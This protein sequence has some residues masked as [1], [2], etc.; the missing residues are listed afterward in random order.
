MVSAITLA[1]MTTFG[2]QPMVAR[3]RNN[4]D[5][6]ALL[7]TTLPRPESAQP[8]TRPRRKPVMLSLRDWASS[9]VAAYRVG[10]VLGYL[11]MMYFG[12]SAFIA[13]IPTFE[14]TTPRGWTPIWSAVVVI[15]GLIGGIGAVKAGTE[16][17][18]RE[19]RVFNRIELTGAIMLFL[20]LGTYATVLLILGYGY[21]DAGRASAGAGFVALGIHP[22]IRMLWLIFRPRFLAALSQ[23]PNTG[24]I[25]LIPTGYALVQVDQDGTIHPETAIPRPETNTTSGLK[26]D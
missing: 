18:T 8:P 13:G 15:G 7:G 17:L 23:K 16:P 22:S 5:V 4:R 20:T 9:Q 10:L 26:G 21:G 14:F 2:A 3:S 25:V 11:A 6:D 24:P 19:V 12:T 1:T